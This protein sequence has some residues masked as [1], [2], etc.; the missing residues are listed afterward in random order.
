LHA[1]TVTE[2]HDLLNGVMGVMYTVCKEKGRTGYA[3]TVL[4]LVVDW[5]Q[6]W[7]LV[8]SPP[9]FDIPATALWWRILSFISLTDFMSSRVRAWRL[10]WAWGKLWKHP[11]PFNAGTVSLS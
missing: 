9:T 11:S 5:L 3:Y 10:A 2:E 7:L 8:V 4:R 6:L 1:D